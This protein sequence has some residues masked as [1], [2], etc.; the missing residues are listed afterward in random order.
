M[1]PF[2]RKQPA[3]VEQ[4]VTF[5][6]VLCIPGPW[7]GDM[8]VK[9]ALIKATNGEYIAA[10]GA[11]IHAKGNFHC[12][13][14]VCERDDR[15]KKSFTVAGY[16]TGVSENFLNQVENH[17]SVVYITAPTGNLQA[18]QQMAL[19]GAA[20]L[21]AGGIGIKV[22]TAGKAFEKATWLI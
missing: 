6:S 20:L 7:T 1:W 14:E 3:P 19:A 15:M 21:K 10:G 16:V 18:A 4:P 22:E 13:F 8:E 9:L 17:K 5:T 11:M 2:R 12:T